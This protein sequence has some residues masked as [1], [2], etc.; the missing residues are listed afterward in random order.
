MRRLCLTAAT[1]LQNAVNANAGVTSAAVNAQAAETALGT[2]LTKLH[3]DQ[4]TL[5][6]DWAAANPTTRRI[7]GL[8]ATIKAA[9]LNDPA[10]KAAQAQLITAQANAN[11]AV[12]TDLAAI[13]AAYNADAP[14]IRADR[15]AIRHDGQR[16]A[17]RSSPPTRPSWRS[18]RPSSP[19]IWPRSRLKLMSD[20]APIAAAQT[21]L[22]TAIENAIQNA[23]NVRTVVA[24]ATSN[25]QP[26]D[27]NGTLGAAGLKPCLSWAG[28]P[29]SRNPHIVPSLWEGIF[30]GA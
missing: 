17:T 20:R 8:S 26:V 28:L 22:W 25:V 16:N 1:A 27:T 30:L 29:E 5:A 18:T 6:T 12:L 11:V 21:A 13:K 9:V 19:V 2:D 14:A 15:T 24:I 3:T 4:A 7:R 10:V 23:T